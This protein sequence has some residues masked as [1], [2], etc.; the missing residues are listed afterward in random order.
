[1]IK[2]LNRLPE[3]VEYNGYPLQYVGSERFESRCG[4]WLRHTYRY[5]GGVSRELFF[6]MVGDSGS[7]NLDDK[8]T[9]ISKEKAEAMQPLH[10]S[11]KAV[12]ERVVYRTRRP[13]RVIVDNAVASEKMRD[14]LAYLDQRRKKRDE[15]RQELER[16][17]VSR[18][19]SKR[20][21]GQVKPFGGE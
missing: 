6:E 13:A 16:R 14:V 3:Y 2:R 5:V 8:V 20:I 15:R 12:R 17:K 18:D 7:M 10:L 4:L 11:V 19:L 21:R 1:M 9:V